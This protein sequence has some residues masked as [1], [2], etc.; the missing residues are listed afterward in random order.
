MCNV[1]TQKLTNFGHSGDTKKV[2]I[3]LDHLIHDCF[4]DYGPIISQNVSKKSLTKPWINHNIVQCI[5]KM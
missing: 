1:L 5:K 3:A 4:I 2:I